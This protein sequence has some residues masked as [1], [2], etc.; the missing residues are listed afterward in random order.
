M[1]QVYLIAALWLGLAVISAIIAYH[2]RTSVA[3]IEI[4]VGVVTAAIASYFGKADQLGTNLQWL[5]FLASAGALLLTFLAGAELDPE[6][7]Q[8]KLKEV[9]AVGLIGF[10]A[11]FI[12]CALVAYYALGW[13]LQA[14]LLTGVALST[15][16]VAVVYAVM[17]G[18][19]FNKTEYG[20]GILGAC[21]IN[22][23]GTVI[24][25][26]L[27]FS[28]FTYKTVIF[29]IVSIITLGS[30]PFITRFLT[31]V[32]AY[33]TAAIRAKWV[34]FILMGLGA[35]A[36]WSGSEAVL[37]A[38]IVGMVLAGRAA[39]DENWVRRMR[40]LTVGFLTPFYFLRAGML[41]SLPLL[42]TAPLVF[43]L[44]LAGKVFSKIFG[45]Y[46]VIGIFRKDRNEK[47][48][49]SLMMS[50]GLTFGTISALF[51]LSHGIITQAQYSFVVAAVIASAVVPTLIAGY[52]FVPRHLLPEKG[53]VQ[54]FEQENDLS[55][56]G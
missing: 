2:L 38:Y 23:L 54:E 6:V 24:A 28:P 19:G 42:I 35:L 36:T 3:L 44:L 30:L 31:H 9:T 18:T 32:Y 51:G 29:I 7:L 17:L 53:E 55:E 26:G 15:T 11:P 8:K 37:P 5:G 1:E 13:T 12:G 4:C 10:S 40:T 50:T 34:I 39:K 56:E 22:D 52:A 25:L 14:S 46:P 47:W 45:L 16:S 48:Y 43:F 27:L 20:K 41:V 21:F 49:Y 33:H